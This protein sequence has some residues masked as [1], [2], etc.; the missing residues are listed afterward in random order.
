MHNTF[1]YLV[2]PVAANS[3]CIEVILAIQVTYFVELAFSYSICP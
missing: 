1:K 3:V 2:S